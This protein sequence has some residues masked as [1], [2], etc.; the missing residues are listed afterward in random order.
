MANDR[1]P[2]ATKSPAHDEVGIGDSGVVGDPRIGR[3]VQRDNRHTVLV[4]KG[5]RNSTITALD[6]REGARLRTPDC[7]SA[8]LGPDR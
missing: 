4:L 6:D 1:R 8:E 5:A 2:S 3:A 7:R